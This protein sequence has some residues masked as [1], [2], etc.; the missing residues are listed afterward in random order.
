MRRSCDF[1][2]GAVRE[3]AFGALICLILTCAP[4]HEMEEAD[5]L[6]IDDFWET[7]SIESLGAAH[8]Y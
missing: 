4:A 7:G 6:P 1:L 5:L 3:Y 8:S 2:L